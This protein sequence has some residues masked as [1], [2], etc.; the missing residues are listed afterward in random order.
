MASCST[1]LICASVGIGAS[2][3][4]TQSRGSAR[5]GLPKVPNGRASAIKMNGMRGVFPDGSQA[6]LT[7]AGAG[8]EKTWSNCLIYWARSRTSQLTDLPARGNLGSASI[9]GR[10]FTSGSL[11]GPLDQAAVGA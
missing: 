9:I 2:P 4:A 3:C 7:S 11:N 6:K 1:R 8:M 10:F 5:E